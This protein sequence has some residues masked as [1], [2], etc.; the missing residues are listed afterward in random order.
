MGTYSVDVWWQHKGGG[1]KGGEKEGFV[2]P[3]RRGLE[4]EGFGKVVLPQCFNSWFMKIGQ[5]NSFDR[6]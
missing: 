1:T 4:Q 2:A 5:G 3:F 6:L